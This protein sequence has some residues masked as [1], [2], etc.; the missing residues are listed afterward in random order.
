[1]QLFALDRQAPILAINAEKQKTYECPECRLPVRLRSG[2]HRQP[3]YFHIQRSS[4]CR[5]HQKSAEHIQA[6]LKLL[7]LLPEGECSLERPFPAISRI[8]DAVWET[9]NIVFEIQ[10]SPI[11]KQEVKQRTA[12]YKAIGMDVVWVLHDKRFN[13]RRLSAAEHYVR[14]QACYYTN[15]TSSGVGTFYDQFEIIRGAVRKY[16]GPLLPISIHLPRPVN[17]QLMR[18]PLES[19]EQ[20]IAQWSLSFKGDLL[21]RLDKANETSWIILAAIEKKINTIAWTDYKLI[22]ALRRI[23][24]LLLDCL[25]RSCS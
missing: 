6:Q 24:T 25:I 4:N 16:K 18:A 9:A 13:Q 5:Q 21:D 19:V 14:N 22:T 7:A 20:R 10:C 2:P 23:Y 1:M 12:D 11:S 15:I 17:R 3:H 8:A